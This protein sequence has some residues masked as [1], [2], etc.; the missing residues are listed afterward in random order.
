MDKSV[1]T[2]NVGFED[3]MESLYELHPRCKDAVKHALENDDVFFMFADQFLKT[4]YV[5]IT[6]S[7]DAITMIENAVMNEDKPQFFH[8]AEGVGFISE[9]RIYNP[10]DVDNIY[11]R[12]EEHGQHTWEFCEPT[13]LEP[14]EAAEIYA[15]LLFT[16]KYPRPV[17]CLPYHVMKW[18][19]NLADDNNTM[20]CSLHEILHNNRHSL[21]LVNDV[22]L[23]ME[24]N[25]MANVLDANN[26]NMITITRKG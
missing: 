17:I 22:I 15:S 23:Q 13:L 21:P 11:Y 2:H 12:L 9:R 16:L 6:D 10:V 20:Q 3:D 5:V 26:N 24:I 1:T 4:T 8:C 25:F 19:M 18:E 7:L 14:K